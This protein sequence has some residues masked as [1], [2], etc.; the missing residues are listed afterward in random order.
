MKLF[1]V[2][3]VIAANS[4]EAAHNARFRE[5]SAQIAELI[6]SHLED[7]P[8]LFAI[9]EAGEISEP[10]VRPNTRYSRHKIRSNSRP[11]KKA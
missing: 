3:P 5:C 9:R 1:L 7:D 4:D 10:P 6:A 11:K 2:A 8:A